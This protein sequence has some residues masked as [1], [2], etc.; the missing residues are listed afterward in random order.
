MLVGERCICVGLCAYMC[1][2]EPF[3]QC[4]TASSQACTG[5]ASQ[6]IMGQLKGEH[7]KSAVIDR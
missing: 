6:C 1:C 7:D 3:Q 5:E 4:V 2:G